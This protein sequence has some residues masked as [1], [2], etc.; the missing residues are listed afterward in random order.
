MKIRDI[1]SRV[2]KSPVFGGEVS[3]PDF[4]SR[5]FGLHL[6]TYIV[7]DRLTSYFIGSW[8]CIDSYVGWSVFFFDDNPVA[9]ASRMGRKHDTEIEWLSVQAHRD[10]KKYI[11]SFIQEQEGDDITL[12]NL[13]QELGETYKI[14]F[15]AEL[16]S[17]H[18][19]IP[20]LS[21]ENVEIIEREKPAP[22]TYDM[23][24]RVKIKKSDGS[25]LWVDLQELDFPYNLT[26][27]DE[28][29]VSGTL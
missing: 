2:D 22:Q 20:F 14:S 6:D 7:Q 9:V 25:E 23:T 15:N 5:E 8:Y 27:Q 4:A 21:G 26:P 1:V 3:I 19:K 13:D 18:D 17:Y 16:L 11:L 10:V 29:C 24:R 28:N 12:A